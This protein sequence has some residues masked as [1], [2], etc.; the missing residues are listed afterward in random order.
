MT[1]KKKLEEFGKWVDETKTPTPTPA[2]T[3]TP[4]PK[5]EKS[6]TIQL[7]KKVGLDYSSFD[8][9]EV[10]QIIQDS[11][12]DKTGIAK[13]RYIKLIN[14]LKDHKEFTSKM[15]KYNEKLTSQDCKDIIEEMNDKIK[16]KKAEDLKAAKAKRDEWD[17]IVKELEG[18]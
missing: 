12:I 9:K 17:K 7:L 4:T 1:E 8:P 14:N 15:V 18:K 3:P 16:A 11:M 13:N 5:V 10:A 2:S 6:T